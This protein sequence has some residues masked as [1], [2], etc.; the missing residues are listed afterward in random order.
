[1]PEKQ[2][3][4]SFFRIYARHA[5]YLS[6]HTQNT[7]TMSLLV[8]NASAG[9]GKT[10]TLALKY[11]SY[12][13]RSEDPN[14]FKHILAVTFTN[15][16]TAEM[17]ERILA[18]LY[19]LAQDGLD[20]GFLKNLTDETKLDKKTICDRAKK[21]LDAIMHDYDHFRVETIDA[22]FQ[23]LLT[24]I[25][26]E[27]RLPR[28]FNVELDDKTA[29]SKAIDEMLLTIGDKANERTRELVNRFIKN[30]LDDEKG[31]NI[32]KTLKDFAKK[33]L[34][35]TEYSENEEII[36]ELTDDTKRM[37][38]LGNDLRAQTKRLRE[39]RDKLCEAA[40]K[41]IDAVDGGKELKSFKNFRSFVNNAAR[42]DFY[43]LA[44]DM[45][46]TIGSFL[47]DNT[48]QI[49]KHAN[50]SADTLSGLSR[51]DDELRKLKDFIENRASLYW[52][53]LL[54]TDVVDMLGL[55]GIISHKV[56]D[57]TTEQGSFLLARTPGMFS[58]MVEDNDA[59][60]VFERTGTTY[61]HI[62]IDE[63]Q[64]TSTLQW[65]NFRTLLINNQAE[66]ED[67]ML[68]GDVKQSIYRWRGGDWNILQG[69]KQEFPQADVQ[70]KVENYRSKPL[71]VRFN[72]TFFTKSAAYLDKKKWTI[73]TDWQEN[74]MQPL[75]PTDKTG[76]DSKDDKDGQQG[77]MQAIYRDVEQTPKKEGKGYVRIVTS[78]TKDA[79]AVMD[80]MHEQIERL[81]ND[82]GVPFNQM[83]ILVR[84]NDEGD[85][86]VK[87][88]AENYPE[89]KLT[90]DEAFLLS[91]SVMVMCLILALRLL[92]EKSDN[93]SAELL[94]QGYSS[95]L[96]E[97]PNEEE[98]TSLQSHFKEFLKAITEDE[99]AKHCLQTP[100]Y[101]LVRDLAKQL[102]LEEIERKA[103]LGQSAYLFSFM[104]ELVGY[105]NN[106]VSDVAAFLDYW[107]EN[108]C[109]KAIP[110]SSNDSIQILTIH[111]SK[112]LEAHTIFI[113]FA[114]FNFETF[115][116][117]N[118]NWC[119]TEDKKEACEEISPALTDFPV[120]P[121]KFFSTRK[122]IAS[123]FAV[124]L[125]EE[126]KQQRVDTLNT[127]YVA[128]TRAGSNLL[129]WSSYK[130][131]TA[132]E[133]IEAFLHD[134]QPNT[135]DSKD[136]KESDSK[137]VKKPDLKDIKEE[138]PLITEYGEPEKV[139]DEKEK[140]EEKNT[141]K[142]EE[143]K[144]QK[145]KTNP[146]TQQSTDE[147][148][149]KVKSGD[150]SKA[151]FVQSGGARDFM[152]DIEEKNDTAAQQRTQQMR[153]YI[154]EG[155]LRH[156]A[157]SLIKKRED[158]ENAVNTLYNQGL[159]ANED[160]KSDLIDGLRKALDNPAVQEWFGKD[161]KL[162]NEC[163]I[164]YKT[165]DGIVTKRP[166]RVMMKDDEVIVVDYKFGKPNDKYHK[167]VR[168]YMAQIK[169]LMPQKTVNGY[170]WYVAR[171][172][173]EPVL[174]QESNA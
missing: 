130:K 156:K 108:L 151:E 127:L 6:H 114:D 133:L 16:A 78:G 27:L 159:I 99:S 66:G 33:I 131:N 50:P 115:L 135:S 20:E 56:S 124:D 10:Y 71:I 36:E 57:V 68:V 72:N 169:K 47:E 174:S 67:S 110:V 35:T 44:Q 22:F 54:V 161:Y 15:K 53:C 166:D 65:K 103:G 34:F 31:W 39:E 46:K 152:T 138:E 146:F 109:K 2:F 125:E 74:P 144:Q 120:L 92:H 24:N 96:A 98:R 60:F 62:M 162:Y 136:A 145:K 102:R 80:D 172:M 58:K 157:F 14:Y 63:F 79:V 163:S 77:L 147:I 90:S 4:A 26:H 170:L 64:D 25:A 3:R 165:N 168:E 139:E 155:K 113:P 94:N 137:D 28:G 106:N 129:V 132:Y 81:H 52:T 49:K 17:K 160:E 55:L 32:S 88:F 61:R 21:V 83:K 89:C 82:F 85:L 118:I 59:S 91:S 148:A 105:L 69:I 111:K 97:L 142:E 87:H 149:I 1:M 158:I 112:G 23:S 18:N 122:V 37:E 76:K 5:L 9:S 101:E 45:P 40:R 11:I 134:L 116:P 29:I 42:P 123:A 141:P 43:K 30:N 153:K 19:N 104:D 84:K 173:V 117:D 95:L 38:Q 48:S 121:V 51:L 164:L 140:K 100:L 73:P 86:I 7:N 107:D 128:F 12:A 167:Q 93:I 143:K 154:D 119:K 150:L 75:K 13:L 126:R 70:P 171:N 8:Y 41:A